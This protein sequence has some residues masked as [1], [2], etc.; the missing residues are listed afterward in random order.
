MAWTAPRTWAS[1]EAVT[2][3]NM[4]T[5]VSDNLRW[6]NEL[7]P[8]A[9]MAG[10]LTVANG[11]TFATPSYVA[12]T[13]EWNDVTI[14]VGGVYTAVNNFYGTAATPGAYMVTCHVIFAADADGKRGVCL[15]SGA[16]GSG[17][18][19]AQETI[20]NIGATE[21]PAVS[22]ASLVQ[23]GPAAKVYIGIR[24]NSGASMTCAVRFTMWWVAS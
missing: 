3:S 4:N 5:Y 15:S 14:N 24:Q 13:S 8:R 6:L 21:V 22:V 1:N 23:L 17:V 12:T 18:I 20:E 11:S 10:S 16:A 9:A 19:Y 7:R 2:S